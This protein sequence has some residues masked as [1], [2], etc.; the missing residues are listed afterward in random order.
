MCGIF[1][2]HGLEKPSQ[3]RARCIALAKRLRHR[4]PDWSGCYVGQQSVLV[5]ERLAIVGVESGAQPLVSEDG[6]QILAVNGEIYNHV[7]LR[8]HVGRDIKFKTN[9]DC[10]VVLPLYKKY[11]TE[12]CG[13]LDGMFSFVLLDES[14]T[15]SRII[16]ARDPIGIT[17][18]YQ[19]WSSQRPGAV[20]FA[21]EL[22]ALVDDCDEIISFPPGHVYDSADKTTTRYYKPSWWNGDLDGPEA[23]IPTTKA[24]LTL[25]RETLE[26][27]VRKRLMSEVPYGVLLSGGLDSSLI[28]AVAARETEKV[29]KAQYELRQRKLQEASSG[30]PSPSGS[31]L[32]TE[33]ATLAAWPQLHSFSIGL[34]NSPDLLAARK[35]AHFLGTVHHEYVFTVQEG[36]DALPEVIYHL[37]TYDVT[38]VRAS[39]PMYLLSR[40]IKAMGVKMVL[41]GEG[42]DEIFGGYLY[43]HAAPDARSTMAW[44]LEARVP[45]LDKAFLDVAMNVD[46]KEKMFSKGSTQEVDEDG[47][48][49][50]EKY[51]LRKAFD[52][53]PDGKPYLPRSILWRQKEQFSDGVGYSWIDGMKQHAEDTITD[54]QFAKGAER[55]PEDTPATK[56]AYLIRQIFDDLFPSPAA[57]KTAVR[58]IPR[59]DWGC[60]SD[61][62]GRSV[63]IHNAAYS[64]DD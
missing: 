47:C 52:C 63:S 27:A 17:T 39:T 14:V 36:L 8:E 53:S 16:A 46:P 12:L 48:P 22:K 21:S 49:R 64:V 56:E 37:E 57:A 6:K 9:S 25:I 51:I 11:G 3:D 20:F 43:F 40:K 55:W 50:M 15:P 59:G 13:M 7:A 35:A 54:E 60:S 2:A 58:W 44:G 62:S 38:T 19:G 61:P 32:V 1:A 4:G 41:S 31:G 23:T 42:S 18:L 26:A 24:D 5:H 45:F 34:E 28:A 29:A 30:P 33:E 10:E